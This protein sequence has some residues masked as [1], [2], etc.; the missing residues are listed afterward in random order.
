ML[1]KSR[2]RGAQAGAPAGALREAQ[3]ARLGG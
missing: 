3:Y 1:E 2:A